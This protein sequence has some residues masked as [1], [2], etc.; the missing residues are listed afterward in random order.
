MVRQYVDRGDPLE[1][2]NQTLRDHRLPYNAVR[3]AKNFTLPDGRAR[4]RA[5]FEET[6]A[7][8][9]VDNLLTKHTGVTRTVTQSSLSA[10]RIGRN[11]R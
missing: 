7:K 6:S 3:S 5:G 9:V 8:P 1:G 10:S 11:S 4:K 2:I